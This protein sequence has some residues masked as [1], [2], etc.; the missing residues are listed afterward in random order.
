MSKEE[1][2]LR[3]SQGET[4]HD[5]QLFRLSLLQMP[6]RPH[7]Q[8]HNDQVTCCVCSNHRLD[9]GNVS[10]ADSLSCPLS[11]DRLAK[12]YRG[13]NASYVPQTD[14]DKTDYRGVFHE[15]RREDSEVKAE[16]TGFA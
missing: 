14:Q 16:H 3:R 12:E 15:L 10:S 6:Q 8:S 13:K 2:H 7:G 4:G 9:E 5:R 1:V 11:R